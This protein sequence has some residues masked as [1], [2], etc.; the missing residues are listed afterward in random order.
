MRVQG[1]G[2]EVRAGG[3][4]VAAVTSWEI[5][6]SGA[7]FAVMAR[8]GSADEFLIEQAVRFDVAL[9]CATRGLCWQKQPAEVVDGELRFITEKVGG[10]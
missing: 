6:D 8:L 9:D 7:G 4:H 1:R 3:R 2:G 10:N 5:T